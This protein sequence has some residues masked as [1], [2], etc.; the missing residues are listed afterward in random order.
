MVVWLVMISV[1]GWNQIIQYP[2][3]L[4]ALNPYYA[5]QLLVHYPEVSGCWER[6]FSMYNRAEALY[7]DLGHCGKGNIRIT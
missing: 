6:I 2:E 3:I 5:Y 1:L 4:R 7:S